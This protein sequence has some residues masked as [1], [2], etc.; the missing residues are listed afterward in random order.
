MSTLIRDNT[1]LGTQRA[2]QF[3]TFKRKGYKTQQKL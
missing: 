2:K 1:L 3:Q